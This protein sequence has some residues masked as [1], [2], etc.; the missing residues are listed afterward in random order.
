MV[1]WPPFLSV[2]QALGFENSLVG[3]VVLAVV[4]RQVID[5]P[6]HRL[7]SLIVVLGGVV[8]GAHAWQLLLPALGVV[9]VQQWSGLVRSRSRATVGVAL[10]AT[11]LAALAALPGLLAVVQ[12]LGIRHATDA[13]VEAPLPVALLLAGLISVSVLA[14]RGRGDRTLT[15]LWLITVVPALTAVAVALRVR[16]GL[17][18]YYP[19]KLLW[20]SAALGLAPLAVVAVTAWSAMARHRIG[21]V[22]RS[23]RVL[24]P[25][26]SVLAVAF[27]LVTPA[28]AFLGAWSTVRGP[29]VVA[30]ITS[31]GAA[32]AQVV[33]LGARGDD[34]IS[35]ILL[36]FY[37][38]DRSPERTPQSPLSLA[39]ECRLLRAASQP[40]V[41]SSAPP[42]RVRARYACVPMLD[43][44][45]VPDP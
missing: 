8:V 33:W 19:S 34:T 35:R 28:G 24:G 36:D 23:A 4:A 18:V 10:L 39:E 7:W 3:A 42:S 25:A 30:A 31:P 5:S 22:W 1:L 40:T 38:I 15:L 37:R 26:A 32:N 43:V 13:G 11:L 29:D 17:S 20:H 2:Y 41:L 44:E 6:E 12:N 45:R 21:A 16:I 9:V 14:V 27:A